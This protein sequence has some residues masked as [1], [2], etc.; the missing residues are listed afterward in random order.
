MKLVFETHST[1]EDNER[2]AGTGWRPRKLSAAGREQARQMGR[3]VGTMASLPSSR[4]AWPG[5]SKRC[6]SRSLTPRCRSSWDW[7]L[8]ECDYGEMTGMHPDTL[9]PAER[10]DVRVPGG[11]SQREAVESVRWFVRDLRA[12][13]DWSRV[14]VVGHVAT[15]RGLEHSING[16]PLDQ[17]VARRSNGRR[18]GSTVWSET[19]VPGRSPHIGA[20]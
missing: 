7:R 5:R 10:L 20:L 6:G 1:T 2:G 15:W 9:E 8:R 12:R 13:R 19:P 14:L 4:P 17:L 18:G 3:G 16:I 11:E